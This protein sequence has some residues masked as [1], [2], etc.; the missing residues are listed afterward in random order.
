MKFL[1]V[2]LLII[3][4]IY[5]AYLD[6]RPMCVEDELCLEKR[7]ISNFSDHS[8]FFKNEDDK[9]YSDLEKEDEDSEEEE[10]YD[11]EDDIK[12]SVESEED[13]D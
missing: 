11:D 7:I 8:I 5:I 4:T 2:V 9:N 6:A 3:A 13:E 12:E 1:T 10:G